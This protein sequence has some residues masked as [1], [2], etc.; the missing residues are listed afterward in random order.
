MFTADVYLKRR[1][2]LK[3]NLKTGILLFLGN[4]ESPMNYPGNPYRY[5]QDST[6]LYYWGLD[7]PGLA[8]VMDLDDDK[9]T[10]FGYDFSIDDIVWMGPQPSLKSRAGKGGVRE[11][12]PVSQLGE[13]LSSARI[14]GRTI[15]FLPQYRP[16]NTV[17]IQNFLGIQAQVVNDYVSLSF[18]KAVIDQ[19]SMKAPEEIKE[20]E[21]ALEIS[22]EMQTYAME[23]T[24]PG[25]V[26][27][28][29]AGAMEGIARSI[30][31]GTSF[32]TIFSIHG[33]TLHNHYHGNEMKKGDIVVNDSGAE[34]V[35]H[36]SSDITRTFP[37]TGKFSSRQKEIYQ[38][39]LNAQ[40]GAIEAM[41]PNRKFKEVHLLAAR[42]IANGLKDLGIMKGD[43]TEAVKKGAHA[44]FFPHGLGH[45][46]GLDV[47][48]MENLG[49]EYVGYDDKTRRSDQ[50]GLAYLRMAKELQPGHVM[51]VE[52][53]IYF[54]PELINLW[55]KE[56]KFSSFID[57]KTVDS[58]KNFGGIR[59]EDDVLVTKNGFRVLGKPIPKTI[60]DV[61]NACG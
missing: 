52:P 21:T 3:K 45:M 46:M 5:R 58:Y 32:P 22:Y 41:K 34:T 43:M 31:W 51:T 36:Y 8:A 19:R 29:I 16:E 35:Q 50:F 23:Y 37:V 53:G 12:V 33:E 15:H 4:E 56:K 1:A 25:M 38:I 11:S 61:E 7:E 2:R 48:D 9:E 27:R 57:Y 13:Y 49:E 42:I 20:I 18:V 6:F 24:K 40:L 10:L 47:H 17:K 44:L 59:I 30:G 26:E 54:I 14:K 60:S 28:E 39:V 55:K